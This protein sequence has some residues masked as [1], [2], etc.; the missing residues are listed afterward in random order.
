[1]TAPSASTLV[2][3][4]TQLAVYEWPGED[5]AVLLVHGAGLHS[6]CWDQ[7]VAHLPGRHCVAFDFPGHGHSAKPDGPWSWPLLG[8]NVIDVARMRGLEGAVVAGHSM[9]GYGVALAAGLAPEL[10]SGLLLV[11]PVIFAP[12]RVPGGGGGGAERATRRRSAFASS[13]EMLERFRDRSPFDRWEPQVLRDYCEHGLL[14]AP[15]GDGF[16]LACEPLLEAEIY[17]TAQPLDLDL[18]AVTMPV[19]V[20][21]A[22]QL[23]PDGTRDMTCSPA[24]PALASRFPNGLDLLHPELGHHMPMEVPG[25][26]ASSIEALLPRR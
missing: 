1:M 2:S 4:G 11:D 25:F 22:R 20:L 24:D 3:H 14:P 15:G 5:P 18:S 7:V 6:R 10:F 16:V 21:R 12:G 26:V 9:G 23:L 17:S 13:D 8:E 19:H